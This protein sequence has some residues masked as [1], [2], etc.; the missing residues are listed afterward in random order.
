MS[1]LINKDTKVIVQGITGRD[2]GFHTKK[3]KEYGTNI[4]GGISPGKGGSVV[5]GVPVFDTV[6]E[7]V[8][9]T[10]ANA[11]VIFVPAPFAGDAIMEASFAGI[12]LVVC[13]TEGVPVK[14]MMKA[15]IGRA[16][17]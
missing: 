17:V 9:A 4:V 5:D 11:S 7:A 6:E 3:M 14:D 1:I 13:I 2:G 12:D 10:G 16:H 15:K 8:K